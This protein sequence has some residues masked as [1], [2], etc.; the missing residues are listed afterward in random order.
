MRGAPGVVDGEDVG[1]RIGV[2]VGVVGGE[3]AGVCSG[4]S[5]GVVGGEEAGDGSLEKGISGGEQ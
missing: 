4:V 2:S 1:V 5:A 3:E